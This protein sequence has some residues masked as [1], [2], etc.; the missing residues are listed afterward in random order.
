MTTP[1][2]KPKQ[3]P[4]TTPTPARQPQQEYHRNGRCFTTTDHVRNALTLEWQTIKEIMEKSGVTYY[5]QVVAVVCVLVSRGYAE[6]RYNRK[7]N[8]E[9]RRCATHTS[10]MAPANPIEST[11]GMEH[12]KSRLDPDGSTGAPEREESRHTCTNLNE[13]DAQVAKAARE[14]VSEMLEKWVCEKE[15]NT[16][17][18]WEVLE[19][20]QSLRAPQEHP[21]TKGGDR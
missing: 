21:S 7:N 18:L 11:K 5:K 20:V 16:I 19:K 8:Q 15:G 6:K 13:H 2:K 14:Q 9:Y 12:R 10:P 4:A 3:C 1:F 17:S